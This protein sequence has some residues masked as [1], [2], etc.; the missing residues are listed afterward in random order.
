[1]E[2]Q[3]V[4]DALQVVADRMSAQPQVAGDVRVGESL[5]REQGDLWL[6]AAKA[7]ADPQLLGRR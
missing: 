6:A 5:R 4:E 2:T 1:V 7:E 3:A